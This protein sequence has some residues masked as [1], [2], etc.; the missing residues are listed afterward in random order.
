MGD[1]RSLISSRREG[2]DEDEGDRV[3]VQNDFVSL[4]FQ[5]VDV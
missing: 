3:L 4:S 1:R 2:E 5:A